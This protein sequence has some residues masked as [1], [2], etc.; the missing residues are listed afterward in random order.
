MAVVGSGRW[1]L[2]PLLVFAAV[3]LVCVLSPPP[4]PLSSSSVLQSSVAAE[5]DT[6]NKGGSN[7]NQQP[8]Q[9]S[10]RAASNATA[11]ERSPLV[12][13]KAPIVVIGAELRIGTLLIIGLSEKG[14]RVVA[15]S[16]EQTTPDSMII[17]MAYGVHYIHGDLNKPS[18][19]QRY[20]KG[21][22]AVIFACQ[23]RSVFNH[24]RE[25]VK[26]T[27]GDT[28]KTVEYRGISTVAKLAV[29]ANV[30]KIM[31]IS[32]YMVTQTKAPEYIWLNKFKRSMYWKRQAELE[33]I[34]QCKNSNTSY[35]IVRAGGATG[36]KGFGLEKIVV[37]Q[38]DYVRGSLP[39]EDL[40]SIAVAALLT[41]STQN[42]VFEAITG[43]EDALASLEKLSPNDGSAREC[44]EEDAALAVQREG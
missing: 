15:V 27:G 43:E 19:F 26:F 37:R 28:P 31:M 20:I 39:S 32:M 5:A 42:T 22:K 29:K 36:E 4:S 21:A 2:L 35:T 12:K 34:R 1:P 30:P 23:A 6:T 10:S 38:G 17:K 13:L 11:K 18:T 7:N 3:A 16:R 40:A 41:N 14:E 24:D 9:P 25:V 44:P 33:L 8:Q